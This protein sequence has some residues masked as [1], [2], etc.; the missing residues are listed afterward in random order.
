M[1]KHV[2]LPDLRLHLR[3][4][5][6]GSIL[7]I[8]GNQA[9]HLN[10]VAT[11]F[12]IAFIDS[13]NKSG[14]NTD[15]LP[16]R[17][18]D[19]IISKLRKKYSMPKDVII[20]DFDKVYGQIITIGKGDA[21]VFSEGSQIKDLS[22]IWEIAPARADLALT[23]RCN[24]KCSFCYVGERKMEE[25]NTE[26]W[27]KIINELWKIG[28]PS[29][30]FTGGEPTLRTDLVELVGSAKEFVTGV[31]TNGRNLSPEL[32]SELYKAQ[33]DYVQVSIES[34]DSGIHD[35]MVGVEG[36]WQETVAGIRHALKSKI[37]V[38][39]NTT[40]TRLNING[41]KNTIKLIQSLGVT[42]IA[43]NSLICSGSGCMAIK[44]SGL[45]EDELQAALID[46]KEY[47]KTLGIDLQ[48][49]S[50]TCYLRLN[51]IDLGFGIKSCSAAK[52]NVTIE[53]NG[54]VIPCQSWFEQKMGNILKDNWT[55]IWDGAYAKSIR[56]GKFVPENCSNCEFM[57]TCNGACHLSRPPSEIRST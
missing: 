39:T 31:I 52:Y 7:W 17:V 14:S 9:V 49:Y 45:N 10:P 1:I 3:E 30:I 22:A 43:C 34:A 6:D 25:L 51:P 18:K 48:W 26:Y 54:D 20:K 8:N 32:C 24:D 28:I 56:D 38:T 41:F 37:I 46:A 16:E 53:P 29:V 50:P 13:M 23:Y 19:D 33:L 12:I 44:D 35:R 2:T 5:K 11:S 27:K 15:F 55:A 42:N 57:P 21:C 36:A 47:A 4:V 40:L